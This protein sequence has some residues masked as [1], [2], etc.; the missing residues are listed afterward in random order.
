MFFICGINQG[1]KELSHSQLV[2][3]AGCGGYGRYQVF[4]TYMCLSLFFIPVLKWG[5]KYYVKMSCCGAVY[6]LNPKTGERIAGGEKVDITQ[7]DLTLIQ[8]GNRRQWQ[9]GRAEQSDRGTRRVC[10]NC[11]YETEEDFSFC[12]KCGERL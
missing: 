2:V 9:P 4:M 7:R 12:P 10:R 6:E 1:Q 5:R 11:G 8:A 3:C